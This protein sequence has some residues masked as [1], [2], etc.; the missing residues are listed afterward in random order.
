M[1]NKPYI[2]PPP[3]FENPKA[4]FCPKGEPKDGKRELFYFDDDDRNIVEAQIIESANFEEFKFET[5]LHL[6]KSKLEFEIINFSEARPAAEGHFT[7][8]VADV[9]ITFNHN[10]YAFFFVPSYQEKE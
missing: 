6:M 4:D 10:Y 8:V 7:P 9:V 1:E 3:L 5:Y 2:Q